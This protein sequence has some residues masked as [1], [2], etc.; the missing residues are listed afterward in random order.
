METRASCM[1]GKH[2]TFE[3]YPQCFLNFI[4]RQGLA[5]FPRLTSNLGS[6][7]LS[8]FSSR[9]YRHAISCPAFGK[10]SDV[11]LFN[12]ITGVWP[13]RREKLPALI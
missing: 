3:L 12:L 11:C 2:C 6:S 5:K 4:L 1:L 8:L 10:F 13:R 9:D 7:C